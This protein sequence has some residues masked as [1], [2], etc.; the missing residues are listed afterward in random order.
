M[1][2]QQINDEIS[3][4]YYNIDK[5]LSSLSESRDYEAKS[6]QQY[7]VTSTNNLANLLSDVLNNLEI[8]MQPNPGQ[9]QGDMQLPDIIMSQ[10]DLQKQAEQMMNGKR[11]ALKNLMKKE[12]KGVQNSQRKWQERKILAPENQEGTNPMAHHH[13]RVNQ[14]EINMA[15]QKSQARRCFS[16]T[17]SNKK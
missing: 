4:V 1:I 14:K 6:A 7:T 12:S 11:K 2:S 16:C 13:Q 9:G 3:D 5:T 10:E 17:N 15:T 8:Q